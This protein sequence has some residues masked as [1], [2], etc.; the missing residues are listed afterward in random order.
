M[1]GTSRMPTRAQATSLM[2]LRASLRLE[3]WIAFT[4]SEG[5]HQFV[6]HG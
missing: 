2:M 5:C 3:A 1:S 4:A 6:S